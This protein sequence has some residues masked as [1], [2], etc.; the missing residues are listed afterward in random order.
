M[1]GR[2]KK[3]RNVT[4]DLRRGAHEK[5]HGKHLI[6]TRKDKGP[7]KKFIMDGI[8]N[9]VF[10]IP[11]V[12]VLN[13]LPTFGFLGITPWNAESVY[14]YMASSLIIAFLFGGIFGRVLNFWRKKMDYH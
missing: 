8:V 12:I 11:I 7:V 10:F 6:I 1:P 14:S 13:T 4:I 3:P 9:Y 5:K 2:G